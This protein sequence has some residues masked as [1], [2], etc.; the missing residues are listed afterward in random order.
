MINKQTRILSS[1]KREPSIQTTTNRKSFMREMPRWVNII[2]SDF[3]AFIDKLQNHKKLKRFFLKRMNYELNLKSPKSFN[4]KIQWKKLYDRNPLITITADKYA[5]RSY[6]IEI[7]GGKTAEDVLI[8]L[9]F[10][11]DTPS[12]IPFENLPDSF[13]I[14]PNHGSNMHMIVKNKKEADFY[15]IIAECKKWLNTHHGI[16][17]YEW[18]YR[19]I[20]RKIIIEKLL[21]T[22]NGKLPLDY[23]FFCIHGRCRLIRAQL[24]RFGGD[25]VTGYYNEDWKLLPVYRPGYT[26]TSEDLPKPSSLDKMIEL[27]EKIS[28]KF[29][30]AR[31]D[32]YNCD[33]KIYFG[34]ITH[35]DFQGLARFE[36]ESYDFELGKMWE[37]TPGYWK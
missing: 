31:V 36:P 10:V 5:V 26:M 14:K 18:A 11:T 19:N 33:G 21:T 30:Q 1:E 2:Y 17:N 28:S 4:E 9:Y 20:K 35:Y 29:D 22:S 3:L 24:N 15:G 34:E 37:L 16:Y 6:I 8:P 13:V 32:L 23:K 27:V 7:L 12:N 25:V